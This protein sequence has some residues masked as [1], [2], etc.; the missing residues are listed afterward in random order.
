M[1]IRNIDLGIRQRVSGKHGSD[2]R[3]IDD[4]VLGTDAVGGDPGV[5]VFLAVPLTVI[6]GEQM[7]LMPFGMEMM[8][9]YDGVE[10]AGNNRD[11]TCHGDAFLQT[12]WVVGPGSGHTSVPFQSP[13][14]GLRT[15]R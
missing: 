8:S 9:E 5:V 14:Y 13:A 3:E 10:P 6:D 4:L 12:E 7:Y 15:A 11:H 2:V 1:L